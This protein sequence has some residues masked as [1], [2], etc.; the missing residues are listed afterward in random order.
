M[1]KFFWRKE[2]VRT[3]F[4]VSPLLN[5]HSIK[6]YF[7]RFDARGE[8]KAGLQVGQSRKL[9]SLLNLFKE[10]RKEFNVLSEV[11]VSAVGKPGR[12]YLQPAAG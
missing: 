10:K 4:I 5:R 6:F 1:I 3:D 11:P 9:C 7:S 12:D 8:A 2:A